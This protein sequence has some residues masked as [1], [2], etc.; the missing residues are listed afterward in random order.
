MT[1]YLTVKPILVTKL[2][3][4]NIKFFLI[5]TILHADVHKRMSHRLGGDEQQLFEC[6]LCK[7]LFPSIQK[8]KRHISRI[9]KTEKIHCPIPGCSYTANR[10][11][12]FK[13]H[14]KTRIH[15]NLSEQE[16]DVYREMIRQVPGNFN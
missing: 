7:K 13:I 5:Y 14:F 16:L 15:E 12:Y 6:P 10:R 3:K 4:H 2:R 9:H 1:E 8:V 11:D